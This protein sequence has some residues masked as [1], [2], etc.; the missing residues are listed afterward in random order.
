MDS[1][2][3]RRE[4]G[5][6]NE[7]DSVENVLHEAENESLRFGSLFM[8]RIDDEDKLDVDTESSGPSLIRNIVLR[9]RVVPGVDT[10][11]LRE[12]VPDGEGDTNVSQVQG[13]PSQNLRRRVPVGSCP[14]GTVGGHGRGSSRSTNLQRRAAVGDGGDCGGRG[15]VRGRGRGFR[16]DP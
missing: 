2:P 3:L 8:P 4:G 13:S 1:T 11:A 14:D 10:A 15:Q 12:A 16:A 7:D 9:S 6:G 5:G